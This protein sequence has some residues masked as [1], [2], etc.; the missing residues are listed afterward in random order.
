MPIRQNDVKQKLR[1]GDPVF[2]TF[3]RLS[4]PAV[5][6]VLAYSGFEFVVI[7]GEHSP[8]GLREWADLV[9]AADAVNLP[10]IVRV[11]RNEPSI[12]M[13]A[14]DIGGLGVQVPQIDTVEEAKRAVAA[15]LYAPL[16]ARGFAATHRAAGHGFMRSEEYHRAANAETLLAIYV[17]SAQAVLAAEEIAALPGID[18]LF[19]GP[20]DLSNSYGVPGE[21]DHSKVQQAIERVAQVCASA[22]KSAGIIAGTPEA[23]RALVAR[24]YQYIIYSSDLGLIKAAATE[25]LARAR[26]E[27]PREAGA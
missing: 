19:V 14:L 27:L 16:G 2:G 4:D 20:F 24:G 11:P 5:V 25:G 17:E 7:D 22:G 18:V 12:I 9:R 1:S 6:E 26:A 8:L 21:I 15:A 23:A 13:Q 3:V 10:A